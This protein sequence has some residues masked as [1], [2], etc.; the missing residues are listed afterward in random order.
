MADIEHKNITEA[1]LHEP[2]GVS[3]AANG[4]VY[5]ADGN[6]S[7]QWAT[8]TATRITA[9]G[10]I[11]GNANGTSATTTPV[12]VNFGT[13]FVPDAT[14]TS[15][16]F[17]ISNTGRLTYTGLPAVKGFVAVSVYASTTTGSSQEYFFYLAKNGA[18]IDS[19]KSERAFTS[20]NPG[21][22]LVNSVVTFN[23]NDYVELF[24]KK[25]TGS[26][27]ITVVT[28]SLTADAS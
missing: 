3:T 21:A 11:E 26:D 15:S 12:V 2:K 27:T 17:T 14:R 28:S 8:L 22:M 25:A 7:G 19:S 20:S 24:V 10:S 23:T 16:E 1:N 13:S 9:Q 4:Q 18:V 6:G 5:I